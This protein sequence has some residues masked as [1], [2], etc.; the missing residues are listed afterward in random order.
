MLYD[1]HG[2]TMPTCVEKKLQLLWHWT[3]PA[4]FDFISLLIINDHHVAVFHALE[5]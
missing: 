2:L 3:E 4:L 1:A 5:F